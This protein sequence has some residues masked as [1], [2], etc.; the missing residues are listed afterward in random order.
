MDLRWE[1]LAHS[2][3]SR[4][5]MLLVKTE[6]LPLSED[7]VQSLTCHDGEA[8]AIHLAGAEEA[9]LCPMGRRQAGQAEASPASSLQVAGGDEGVGPPDSAQVDHCTVIGHLH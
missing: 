6:A 9:S 3:P 1:F 2:R 4:G 7:T 5:T 8:T